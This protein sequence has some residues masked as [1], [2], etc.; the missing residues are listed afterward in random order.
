MASLGRTCQPKVEHNGLGGC[1]WFGCCESHFGEC[2][3]A[4][5]AARD[6][7]ECLHIF[8]PFCQSLLAWLLLCAWPQPIGLLGSA[9]FAERSAA[10]Q[11]SLS[12]F[13]GPEAGGSGQ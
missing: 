2:L 6:W 7:S 4:E 9:R 8:S 10:W 13:P 3:S 5:V 11:G 1:S 12:V